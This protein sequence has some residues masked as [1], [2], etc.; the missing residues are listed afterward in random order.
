MS[1]C[2]APGKAEDAELLAEIALG[3]RS[4]EAIFLPGL[5]LRWIS[6]SI[7][8]LTG[9]TAADCVAAA[10]PFELLVFEDDRVFCRRMAQRV[11]AE[12]SARTGKV[13]SI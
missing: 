11:A 5:A 7:E 13:V 9:F 4:V 2:P 1:A 3:V 6:P 8:A 12:E 10:D